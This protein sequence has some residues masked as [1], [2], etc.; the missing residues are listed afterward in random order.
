MTANLPLRELAAPL[1]PSAHGAGAGTASPLVLV[2]DDD[3]MMRMLV[4][5]ALKS[6]GFRVEEAEDGA[7]GLAS[8][9][10]LRPDVVLL[11]VVMPGM[12]GFATCT[13]LRALPSGARVPVLM[14][15]GLDDA[16][17]INRAYEVGATDFVTKPI[18][19]PILSHRVRYLFRASQTFAALARSQEQLAEAQR[20]AQLGY[21]EW[22]AA[23]NQ[24]FRSDE[25]LRILGVERASFPTHLGATA[26]LVHPD[27]AE[28]FAR[29]LESRLGPGKPMALEHRII[30]PDGEVRLLSLQSK[31]VFDEAGALLRVQGTTQDITERRQTEERMRALTL[32]DALTGLPN[33]QFF[34]ERCD[35]G[36]AL[37]GRLKLPLAIMVLDIDRFQRINETLGY[38]VGDLLLKEIGTRLEC[39]LR[40]ADCLGRAGTGPDTRSVARLGGDEFTIMLPALA[41][42]EDVAKVAQRILAEVSRPVRLEGQE[43]VVTASVGIAVYPADG[44]DTDSLLRNADSAMHFAKQQGKNNHQYF[45]AS[46]N[47]RSAQKL[48]LENGLRKAIERGELI[49]HYQPKV[50]S[51]SG[52]I[53]GVEALV[54]WNR[55]DL[56]M[57]APNDFIP[58]AEETGLIVPIGEWVLREAC[59]QVALWR[60]DGFDDLTVAVNM[61]S[62]NFARR[63]FVSRVAATIRE[64]GIAPAAVEIEVTESVLMHDINAT[65][66]TLRA[67]KDHGLL[68]SVDDFGTGYSSLSYLKKFPIDTL[69]IDRSFVRDVMTNREDAAITSAVI[70]LGA[71]LDLQV[72]A[73]GV[74]TAQQAAF[75]RARGCHLMQGYYFGRPVGA[76]EATALLLA[77]RTCGLAESAV[78]S[79]GGRAIEAATAA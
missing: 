50:D 64:A 39:T 75:L 22:D 12:D 58:L 7:A 57:V 73:E 23:G 66:A 40:E 34:R 46:M 1:P 55:P 18:A 14:M 49:L 30:R 42:A 60:A 27:D 47:T 65:I 71:S 69:K 13:A 6:G 37:A 29:A 74:E 24:V 20:M 52:R 3:A 2:I 35:H 15:T 25:L 5:E 11:D 68:L 61:A 17:S 72:V 53:A 33:R 38:G 48:S 19:W 77:N 32:Y 8:F 67:L 56:G 44:E 41:Q 28:T 36:L 10:D 4:C 70:A 31:G 26:A 51:A 45:S 59:R 54:R 78:E 63:D 43:I 21:W 76:V 62:P 16:G 9:T 79:A